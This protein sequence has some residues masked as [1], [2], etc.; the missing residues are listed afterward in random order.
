MKIVY[1]IVSALLALCVIPAAY[2]IQILNY[3]ISAVVVNI[4]ENI[5]IKYMYDEF[6][7]ESSPF[8]GLFTGKG[9][10][11]ANA[12]VK[13]LMPAGICFA[14]FFALALILSLVIFFFAV[15]SKKQLVITCLGGAGL[16][17]VIGMYISFGRIAAPLLKGT[18]SISSIL[19]M[20]SLGFLIDSAIKIKVLELTSAPLLMGLTFA[21]I[22]IW[23]FAFILTDDGSEKR[24][25]KMA[26]LAKKQKRAQK[27]AAN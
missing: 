26:K 11:F 2:F 27:K 13:S 10:M 25:A 15:F 7:D 5:S 9:D 8:H 14:V 6:L 16:L 18:I 1:R 24:A 19:N 22:V 20:Q 21:A 17:S 23:G 4:G 12:A 3:G